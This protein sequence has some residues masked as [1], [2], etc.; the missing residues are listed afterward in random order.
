VIYLAEKWDGVRFLENCVEMIEQ[1]WAENVQK[2]IFWDSYVDLPHMEP[3]LRQ[4]YMETYCITMMGFEN[5]SIIMQG[6]LLETLVKEI[7]FE[8]EKKDFQ[9]PFG[10]AID[11][12]KEKGYLTDVEI[13]FLRRFKNEIRNP[14]QHVDVKKIVGES[15]ARGWWIPLE[16]GKVGESLLKGIKKV[17]K[18]EAGPGELV[19]YKDVRPVGTVIKGTIDKQR[20]LPLF[21]HVEKF[22]RGLSTKHFKV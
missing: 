3:R 2:T 7:I 5:V 21:L 8:K 14:Y 18:R 10:D 19:G 13:K 17:K 22:V 15:K 20:A 11:R 6:V 12:C 16:K 1:Q 4:I 9:K